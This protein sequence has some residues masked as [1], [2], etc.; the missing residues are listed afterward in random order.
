M[1]E[2]QLHVSQEQIDDLHDRLTRTR[3]PGEAAGAGWDHG[4]PQDRVR[5]LAEHWAKFDWRAHEAELNALPQFV[6]EI[7]GERVYFM[8]LRNADRRALPLV[9][10][11]G[12]PGSTVEFLD[13]A[14][15]LAEHFHVVIPGI[16]GYG[17][18]GP[19]TRTGWGIRRV[20][21]AWA[22]LMD[23]LGYQRYGAQGGDWGSGVSRLLAAEAPGRVVGV[24]VNYLPT[25]GSPDGLDETD[26]AR[27]EKT[28]RLA[29]NRHPHQ[30][31]FAAT[32]QTPAYALNDSPAGQLAFLAEKFD[33]WADPATPVP[34]DRIVANVAHHWFMGTAGSA[35]RLI[36]ES[37]RPVTDPCPVPLG[38]AVLPGDIVQSV[39]PLAEQR[40]DVRHWT[41]FER[42]GHFAALEVPHAFAA[43]V[44]A[45]FRTLDGR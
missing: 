1:N 38:V 23:R 34:D 42:G 13:V 7:G 35:A 26:R 27:V 17:L 8:H 9:L 10:T 31:L 4:I 5:A 2:F 24:H 21:R 20:A 32:P 19:T 44:T 37:F 28:V 41:E 39:R 29:A 43:D 16:P 33:T 6:T 3:W 18:S 22:E 15:S 30:I 45:F 25:P 11:H 12:W 36:K 40:F 14:R